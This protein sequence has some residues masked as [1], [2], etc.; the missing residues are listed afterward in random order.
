MK[1]KVCSFSDPLLQYYYIVSSNPLVIFAGLFYWFFLR[2]V[3]QNR[4]RGIDK[5]DPS[6]SAAQFFDFKQKFEVIFFDRK[7]T[8]FLASCDSESSWAACRKCCFGKD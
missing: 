6:I 4:G 2:Q 7:N 5:K 3:V 8:R 1:S